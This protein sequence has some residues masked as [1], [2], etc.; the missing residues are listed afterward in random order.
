M[1]GRKIAALSA[2]Q[3]LDSRGKPTVACRTMLDDGSSAVVAVPSGASTGRYEAVERR[4]GGLAYR[5]HGVSGAVAAVNGPIA[6][7]LRGV[8]ADDQAEID[9]L[10]IALDGTRDLSRLGANATLAASLA[11]LCA[12]AASTDV[13]LWRALDPNVDRLPRPMVNIVSGGAHA[14][15]LISI[16]DVLFVPLATST[17]AEAI[18]QAVEVRA[19][20]A[21]VLT[22]WGYAC[23]LIA[24][25]GGLAAPLGS[26]ER[27]VEAVLRGI[28]RAGLAPGTE[29][30]IAVDIAASQFASTAGYL[31]DGGMLTAGE[32]LER[33]ATWCADYPVVLIEDPFD[34]DDWPAWEAAA[35]ALPLSLV[36]DD[37][38]ATQV[39]RVQEVV[40]RRAAGTLLVKV[41]QAGTVS[42]AKSALD[43]AREGGLGVVVSARSGETED[44]W[45]ADLAIGWRANLLKVGSTMRS[46]RNAKWN[47][48]LQIEQEYRISGLAPLPSAQGVEE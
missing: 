38:A 43:V 24:D 48:V 37:L 13:D 32:W 4:D 36:A 14:D 45:L 26:S 47:R 6:D 1:S 18:A 35:S 3:V 23:S 39:A 41:N 2:W 22:T 30:G 34:Q 5:G 19:A 12:A 31:V 27:A 28:E 11:C 16:Q 8:P 17:F 40:R 42:A 44:S 10:L 33:M 20:T 15:G 25:E 29:G 21:D 7:V 46:E 9:R